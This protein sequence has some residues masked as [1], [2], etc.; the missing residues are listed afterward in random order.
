MD[1]Y[2]NKQTEPVCKFGPGGDFVSFWPAEKEREEYAAKN[3]GF[4]EP[5]HPAPDSTIKGD[6][7]F[8]GEPMLFAD[9]WRVG[10]AVRHKPKHGIRAHHR[11][12][13]KR[14]TVQFPR[15]GSLFNANFK[16]AKSA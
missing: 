14:A 5:S 1:N 8:S 9:D 11:T 4:E 13:T 6:S 12:A 15:Q 16:S 7:Q 3:G 2:P 10:A